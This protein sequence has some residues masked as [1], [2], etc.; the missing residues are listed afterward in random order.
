MEQR[1]RDS[2]RTGTNGPGPSAG[3]DCA[4]A[5]NTLDG[6]LLIRLHCVENP[7]DLCS[8]DISEQRLTLVKNEDFKEFDNIVYINA[9][10]NYLSIESFRSFGLLRELD[11]SL[12]G[13]CDMRFNPEDFPHLEVLD[14]SYNNVS[15][16]DIVCLGRLAGLKVLCLTGN[17]L[18]RLPA[19][20]AGSDRRPA[21]PA[22]GDS[23]QPQF[24]ALETLTLDDN[25]LSSDVFHSLANLTRLQ[26]LNLQGNNI[27]EIPSMLPHGD[28]GQF[29][30]H[31][32]ERQTQTG[33]NQGHFLGTSQPS[34]GEVAYSVP[35]PQLRFLSL[36]HNKIAEEEALL[37]AAL[38][39][40]LSEL[41]IHN[42]PLTSQRTGDPP[43]L[44]YLL[45]VRRGV[46]VKRVDKP[47][48]EKPS[49]M[50]TE[51]LKHKVRKKEKVPKRPSLTER[52][53]GSL[54]GRECQD[55]PKDTSSSQAKDEEREENAVRDGITDAVDEANQQAESFFFTQD[56]GD[57]GVRTQNLSVGSHTPLDYLALDKRLICCVK[58]QFA[59]RLAGFVFPATDFRFR[60]NFTL[61]SHL[62]PGDPRQEELGSDA[63]E[64]AKKTG[65]K[66]RSAAVSEKFKDHSILMDAN[67]GAADVVQQATGLNNAGTERRADTLPWADRN[68]DRRE[69]AGANAAEADA[70]QRCGVSTGGVSDGQ[71]VN[72]QVYR[73]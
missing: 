61:S 72:Q 30:Q 70:V 65:E 49:V 54:Q 38:F 26:H 58:I 55:V 14:L 63:A 19:D 15:E 13:C 27:S 40:N 35:L 62:Q 69:N 20:M 29:N 6:S 33:S 28:G 71:Q 50:L 21:P 31:T 44:T 9:W 46:K 24:G 56:T 2:R 7:S 64:G 39:P 18:H 73:D 41:L 37:A 52:P 32:T 68:P 47:E 11:L 17:R 4:A 53:H 67:S 25:R 12:N 51:S 45:S 8:I 22:P 3:S 23:E 59:S 42:N 48:V 60:F 34:V 5:G 16:A 43:L 57:T 10:D 1:G 36:A 66:K